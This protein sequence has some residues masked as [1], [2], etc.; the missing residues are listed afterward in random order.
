MAKI[1]LT[2]GSGFIGQHTLNIL[3][4]SGHH[5]LLPSR[6]PAKLQGKI[7]KKYKN[8]LRLVPGLFYAPEMLKVYQEFQPEFIVHLAAIRG[9]GGGKWRDYYEVNVKGTQVLVD[10]ALQNSI[11]KFIFCSTVGVFGTIPARL[12]ADPW[13]PT[14]PDNLYH[15]SKFIAENDVINRLRLNLPFVIV[16]PTI[17]YGEGDNGFVAK[18]VALVKKKFF[19]L[20]NRDVRIH[21][22]DVQ[23]FAQAVPILMEATQSEIIINLADQKPILLNNLVQ[24]LYDFFHETP[25]VRR[26]KIPGMVYDMVGYLSGLMGMHALKTSIQLI[27]QSWYYETS[28]VQALGIK[29]VDTTK[30]IHHYLKAYYKN[31]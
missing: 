14:A 24:T 12:P 28:H 9:E 2:G 10:F 31:E 18:L 29:Q 3:L 21:L 22:L 19:P 15:K 26:F 11:Q 25:I 30:K 1:V 23:T 13:A 6:H 17:T 20:I 7:G 16:R 5:I 8:Q 27:S 4:K